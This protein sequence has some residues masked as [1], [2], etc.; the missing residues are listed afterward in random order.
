MVKIQQNESASTQ[1][2]FKRGEDV[3]QYERQVKN[4]IS[5]LKEVASL[6]QKELVK[7]QDNEN[8]MKKQMST[9]F[10]ELERSVK[11]QITSINDELLRLNKN[12]DKELEQVDKEM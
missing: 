10:E 11:F 7:V 3:K 1:N 9:R 4:Q 12:I 2:T 8:A 6:F 5:E